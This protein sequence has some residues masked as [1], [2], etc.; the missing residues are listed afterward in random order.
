MRV[1]NDTLSPS[2]HSTQMDGPPQWAPHTTYHPG[3]TVWCAGTFW[4]CEASHTS[5]Q[6]LSG[7]VR[8]SLVIPF[9][10]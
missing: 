2:T 3:N 8:V 10:S 6:G 9:G 5:G 4:R 7:A 1:V